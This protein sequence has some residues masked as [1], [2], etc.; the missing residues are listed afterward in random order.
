[1]NIKPCINYNFNLVKLKNVEKRVGIILKSNL[2]KIFDLKLISSFIV[3]FLINI[4]PFKNLNFNTFDKAGITAANLLAY[5][6]INL[7]NIIFLVNS[8]LV[9]ANFLLKMIV[10]AF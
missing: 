3:R 8:Y 7:F 6:I 9:F 10:L 1:M 5:I 2:A 4:T